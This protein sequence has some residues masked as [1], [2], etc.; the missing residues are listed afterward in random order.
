MQPPLLWRNEELHAVTEEEQADLVVVV[1]RTEGQDRSHLGGHLALTLPDASE[2]A[3]GTDIEHDHHRHLP[4]LG[5][6]LDVG[7]PCAGRDVPV[8][9]ADLVAR[10]VGPDLFEVHPAPLEDALVLAGERRLHEPPRAE[11]EAADL[12]ENLAGIVHRCF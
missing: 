5:E 3:G 6:L 1:N 11:F 9:R 8:D 7:L 10:R 12:A 4:L 2:V